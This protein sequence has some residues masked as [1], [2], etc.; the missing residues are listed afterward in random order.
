LKL[1]VLKHTGPWYRVRAV[2][3]TFGAYVVSNE[4]KGARHMIQSIFNSLFGCSHQRTTFPI[5]PG[6]KPGQ[7]NAGLSAPVSART[8]TYVACLD[9]GKEFAYDWKAMRIGEPLSAPAVPL[10]AHEIARDVAHNAAREAS[11]EA[12]PVRA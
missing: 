1:S 2:T 11:N 6:R 3:E 7:E 9:C 10:A 8:A 4:W 12:Q 5:T